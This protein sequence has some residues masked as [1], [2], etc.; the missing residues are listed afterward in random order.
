MKYTYTTL[1]LAE[2]GA[3]INER[4]VTAVLEAAD[5]DVTES[6]VKATIAALEGVDVDERAARPDDGEGGPG[7]DGSGPG[8]DG[9]VPP[10]GVGDDHAG[11]GTGGRPDGV[12]AADEV[13][14]VVASGDGDD[15]DG[16]G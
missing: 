6:R 2:T 5:A 12:N 1:L 11:N 13:K 16:R 3:E 4:N 10:D 15:S 9:S 14:P 8:D 7:H